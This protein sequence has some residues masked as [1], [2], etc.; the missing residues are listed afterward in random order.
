VKNINELQG[1]AK[2]KRDDI[3]RKLKEVDGLSIRQIA[4]ITRKIVEI[5]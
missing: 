2:V 5:A 1:F 4:R 3:I